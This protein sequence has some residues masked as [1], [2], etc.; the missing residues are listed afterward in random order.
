MRGLGV[1]E[2]IDVS[3][4]KLMLGL[5]VGLSSSHL[6]AEKLIVIIRNIITMITIIKYAVQAQVRKTI[7]SQ[8]TGATPQTSTPEKNEK[9]CSGQQPMAPLKP[10][11]EPKSILET[12]GIDI[13]M[14]ESHSTRAAA[15]FNCNEGNL[16]PVEDILRTAGWSNVQNFL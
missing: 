1:H 11:I 14:Y 3:D 7:V 4:T 8:I 15:S 2:N 16:L 12:A 6:I 10:S 9:K 13:S 5:R